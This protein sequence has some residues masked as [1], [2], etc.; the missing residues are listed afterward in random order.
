ML[1]PSVDAAAAACVRGAYRGAPVPR[2]IGRNV[3]VE[4]VKWN[5]DRWGC[6]QHVGADDRTAAHDEVDDT[7]GQTGLGH[8]SPRGG[9]V[10]VDPRGHRP[11]HGV[12]GDLPCARPTPPRRPESP[13]C[14]GPR[15][16]P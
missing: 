9:S 14:L 11:R 7:V 10:P 6:L 4:P 12:V 1:H 15:V 8:Q 13:G 2:Q 16:R 3:C 5:P